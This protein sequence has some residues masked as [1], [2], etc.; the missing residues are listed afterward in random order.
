MKRRHLISCETCGCIPCEC[1]PSNPHSPGPKT[2]KHNNTNYDPA[3]RAI[4]ADAD[5]ADAD[6]VSDYWLNRAGASSLAFV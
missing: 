3:N 5:N 1:D 2:D 4:L 6:A